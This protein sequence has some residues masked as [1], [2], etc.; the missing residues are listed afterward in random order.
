[1]DPC[2][3][4][5]VLAVGAD[6]AQPESGGDQV[7]ELAP[8]EA[9]VADEDQPGPQHACTGGAGQQLARDL[10]FP[11]LRVGQAPRHGHPVR[12]GDQVQ[13]INPQYQRECAAQYP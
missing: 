13:L 6:Q 8:G 4:C 1:M 11:D 9:L 5:L 2:R 10:A 12:G 7:L 3:G